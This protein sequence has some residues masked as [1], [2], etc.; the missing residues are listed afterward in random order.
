MTKVEYYCRVHKQD[1][2]R[3]YCEWCQYDEDEYRYAVAEQEERAREQQQAAMDDE[4]DWL[5]I[6]GE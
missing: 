6:G 1:L 2:V 5:N 3:D 4:A